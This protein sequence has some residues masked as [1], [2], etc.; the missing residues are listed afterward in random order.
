MADT[1]LTEFVVIT[2]ISKTRLR[3]YIE[4]DIYAMEPAVE[5][6]VGIKPGHSIVV[7]TD[8][9]NAGWLYTLRTKGV[10]KLDYI[11]LE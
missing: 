7:E 5:G 10:I 11:E 1:G 4:P 2:N 6:W 8:R 3:I 9:V